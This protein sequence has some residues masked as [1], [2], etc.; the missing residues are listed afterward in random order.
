ME[1]PED[2]QKIH[3]QVASLMTVLKRADRAQNF[4][5]EKEKEE[6]LQKMQEVTEEAN[7]AL[8]KAETAGLEAER[9]RE[10]LAA[11][12]KLLKDIYGAAYAAT[13]A[14]GNN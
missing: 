9:L 13:Q 2:L 11:R 12:D 5:I 7:R 10:Q 8:E 14:E 6:I 3:Q 1:A 4:Q